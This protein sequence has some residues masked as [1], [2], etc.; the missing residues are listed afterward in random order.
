MIPIPLGQFVQAGHQQ[1]IAL[2]VRAQLQTVGELVAIVRRLTIMQG[3][4]CVR[5]PIEKVYLGKPLHAI[6]DTNDVLGAIV[7]L[8]RAF[9]IVH[10][11]QGITKQVSGSVSATS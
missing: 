2:T 10:A 1:R 8:Q 11:H 6:V 5:L 9:G 3:D 4:E 7:G